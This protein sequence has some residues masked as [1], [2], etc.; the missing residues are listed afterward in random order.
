MLHSF[1]ILF[2]FLISSIYFISSDDTVSVEI[3]SKGQQKESL[4]NPNSLEVIFE[5]QSGRKVEL[6]WDDNVNG[7]LQSELSHTSQITINTFIGHKFYFTPANSNG[8]K[9]NVLYQVIMEKYTGLVTLYN[10]RIM[11]ER[12]QKFEQEKNQFMR[13]Y[14][15]NTGR[16]WKNYYPREPITHFMYNFTHI[17]LYILYISFLHIQHYFHSESRINY[18]YK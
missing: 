13:E 6:Y 2:I 9:E 14:F 3:D 7:V 11:A 12:G 8:S 16:K 15:A 17:G 4:K 5:N 1:S 10:E 18:V